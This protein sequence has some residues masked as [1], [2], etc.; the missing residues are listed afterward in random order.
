MT[1]ML[2]DL[3]VQA[4]AVKGG[5]N[6]AL[7]LA[8]V[9]VTTEEVIAEVLVRPEHLQPYGLVHGGVYAAMIE[10]LCS[11]G[12][13]VNALARG[14][15]TVGQENATSFIRAVRGGTLRGRAVPLTRG[16]RSHVW[17][18]RIEDDQGRLVAV[19]RVRLLCLEAGAEAGG[20]ELHLVAGKSE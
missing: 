16:R 12:A 14:Q 20:E 3:A 19:G 6:T 11:T 5:F 13:A 7:G 15:T 9:R 1:E 2:E 8:F 10:T 4:N 18:A 17:E